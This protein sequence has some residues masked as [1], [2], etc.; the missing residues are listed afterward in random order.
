MPASPNQYFEQHRGFARAQAHLLA[1]RL[2]KHVSRD[3]ILAW[4]ERGLWE[5]SERFDPSR[6][7]S[8]VT[9]A[10]YRIRGAV[11][12]EIRRLSHVPPR[13]LKAVATLAGQDDYVEN[14]VPVARP[15]DPPQE[16]ARQLSESIRGLGMVFLA[17]QARREDGEDPIDA[18]DD[19]DPG[20]A[21]A[22]TELTRRIEEAKKELPERQREILHLHYDKFVSFTDIA[23]RMNVNKATIS[24]EHGRAIEALKKAVGLD[25]G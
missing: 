18:V 4:A 1:K 8:F 21:V 3:D 20:D 10:Y 14:N 12:D 17:S 23:R 9:F 7:N 2:P 24:R 11:F 6:H 19:A 16:Q 22:D 25:G 15:G 13:V 5:A